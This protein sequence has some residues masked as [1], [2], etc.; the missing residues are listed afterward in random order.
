MLIDSGN[1]DA[2]TTTLTNALVHVLGKRRQAPGAGLRPLCVF[3]VH[4]LRVDAVA[5]L[6]LCQASMTARG[7][8]WAMQAR[9]SGRGFQ[10]V[11]VVLWGTGVFC[12]TSQLV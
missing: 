6:S 9:I 5:L 4:P 11:P 1:G 12:I 8:R 2:V 7:R 3:A 10:I